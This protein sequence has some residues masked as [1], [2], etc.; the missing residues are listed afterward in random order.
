MGFIE[1]AF[2]PDRKRQEIWRTFSHEV[3]G[4]FISEGVSG[5]DEIHIPFMGHRITV[6]TIIEGRA[7]RTVMTVNYSSGDFQFK[8][9]GWGG[10]KVPEVDRDPFLNSEFPDLAPRVKVEFNDAKKLTSLLASAVLRELVLEAPA[11][12]TL[13][14][15]SGSLSLDNRAH[16]SVYNGTITDVDHLHAA[17]NLLKCVLHGMEATGSASAARLL[18]AA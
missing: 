15:K 7:S 4:I 10:H 14:A 12:F 18:V 1:N 8:I 9:F 17:F 13:E 6:S 11:Y 5:G 16:G 2:H 3:G